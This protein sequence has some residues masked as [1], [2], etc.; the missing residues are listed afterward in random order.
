M[1]IRL[2]VIDDH[3]L[4][5][6]GLVQYFGMQ[7]DIELVAEAASCQE[8]L[9]KL[10]TVRA[11]ILLLDM[12][13]PGVD[14]RHMISLVKTFYPDLRI[15]ILS[16]HDEVPIVLGAMRAGAS[17]YISKACSPQTLLEAV[18]EV[19]ETGKYLAR[20]MAERLKYASLATRSNNDESSNKNI[21]VEK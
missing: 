3:D 11:D 12:S 13:M 6:E 4:V 2:M 19:M 20:D 21:I 16:A 8:L 5:R 7:P 15:L 1:A 9:G 10:R 17:G 14:G 18:K